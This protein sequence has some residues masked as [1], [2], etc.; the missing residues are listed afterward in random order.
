MTRRIGFVT[1]ED[2]PDCIADD[3][4]AFDPLARHGFVT[5]PIVWDRA[6][7]TDL[8]RF[9]AVIFRSCWNY[10]HKPVAFAAWCQMLLGLSVQTFNDLAIIEWNF[11]KRYVLEL[12]QHDVLIP[13]SLLIDEH[14]PDVTMGLATW[15]AAGTSEQVVVKPAVSM[16][17][18]DTYCVARRDAA[19]IES[20]VRE[21][22]LERDV[23]VQDFVAEV[24]DSGELSFVYF[25]G[26]FSHAV[27]KT[28]AKGEFR[29]QEEHGGRRDAYVPP[30]IE[31]ATIDAIQAVIPGQTLYSRIDVVP[32]NGQFIVMELEVI[33]PMLYLASDSGASDRF[34]D[35]IASRLR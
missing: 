10:H 14:C 19:R 5:E 4:L 2:L 12:A 3:R 15:L 28:P 6:T 11:H 20:L 8:E 27:R 7:A 32:H 22:R 13:R 33:D 26:C 21:I 1:S 30:A 18:Y 17:G 16:S 31:I 29:V 24:L 25:N 34:A 35:A 9:D 23:I